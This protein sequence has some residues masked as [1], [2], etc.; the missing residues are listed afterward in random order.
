LLHKTVPPVPEAVSVTFPPVQKVVAPE[1]VIAGVAGI[2]FTVITVAAD[3]A[4]VQPL[5]IR[6]QVYE[7]LSSTEIALVVAPLLHKTVPVPAEAVSVRLPPS[8]K[9]VAPPVTAIVGVAGIGFTVITVAADTAEVQP[10]AIRR[11]VYEPAVVTV[12]VLAVVPL[13]HK[14]VPPLPDGVSITLPPVQKL[15]AAEAVIVGVAGIGV[16][17]TVIAD[18]AT[19]LQPALV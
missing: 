9:V 12:S 3:T 19:E 15:V 1:A 16:A 13:L 14:T 4:D 18:E 8:Q 6:R 11:Q 5:A 7:P 17:V 2:G 10:L